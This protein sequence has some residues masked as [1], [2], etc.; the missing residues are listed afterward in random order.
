MEAWVDQLKDRFPLFGI[1]NTNRL[2]FE[3]V[4]KRYPVIQKIQK[5]VLSYE[6]GTVKPDPAIYYK[7]IRLIGQPPEKIFYV[8][9]RL[10]LVEAASKLG[11]QSWQFTGAD[12]FGQKLQELGAQ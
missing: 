5:W 2:H 10:E 3:Y 11:L 6:V 1:S 7:A 9:D 12:A 4:Y 8:D